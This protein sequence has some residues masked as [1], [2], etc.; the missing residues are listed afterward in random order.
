MCFKTR[1]RVLHTH[2]QTF[3]AEKNLVIKEKAIALPSN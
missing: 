2:S 1:S 3:E